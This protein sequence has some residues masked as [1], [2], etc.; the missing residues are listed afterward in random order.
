MKP[1]VEWQG[2]KS[3]AGYGQKRL[4]GKTVYVHRLAYIEAHGEIPKGLV[5]RHTCY[6]PACYNVDHLIIGTQKQNMQ[7]CS[8]RG[9]VNKAIKATGEAQGLSK[10]T[11]VSVKYIRESN[12]SGSKLAKEL[13]VSRSTVNRVRSGKTWRNI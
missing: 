10:L 9:R 3:T 2:A 1:C 6:N 7:D 12:L 4:N 8:E 11:E 5:V 13:G